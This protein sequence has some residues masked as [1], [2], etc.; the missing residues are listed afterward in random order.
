MERRPAHH[1]GSE[2]IG[3]AFDDGLQIPL[4]YLKQGSLC[5]QAVIEG[6]WGDAPVLPAHVHVDNPVPD[7][8]WLQLRV[9]VQE[10]GDF[11][12]KVINGPADR[13]KNDLGDA[14]KKITRGNFSA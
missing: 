1:L 7:R 13:I 2:Q 14:G 12:Q 8:S 4:A 11:I 5:S 9:V 3:I 6:K 10:P